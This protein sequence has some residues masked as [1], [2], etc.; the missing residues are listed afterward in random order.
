M[1][2]EKCASKL[3]GLGKKITCPVGYFLAEVAVDTEMTPHKFVVVD[4]EDIEY[5]ALLGFNFVSK[6]DF[7]LSADGYK[8]SSPLGDHPGW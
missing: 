5:V 7:T 1:V 6:L 2:L 8:F 4:D 3:C